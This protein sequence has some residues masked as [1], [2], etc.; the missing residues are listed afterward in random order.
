VQITHT[1]RNAR[2]RLVGTVKVATGRLTGD[3]QV[4]M[5][6]RSERVKANVS[7]TV[8]GLRRKWVRS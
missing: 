8:S 3:R 4:A 5:Q 6:G 1:L 2:Q 7:E